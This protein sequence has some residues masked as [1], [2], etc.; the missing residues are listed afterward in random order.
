M[1]NIQCEDERLNKTETSLNNKYVACAKSDCLI[2]TI[3]L[4][5][6]YFLLLVVNCIS[7]YFYNK[8]CRSG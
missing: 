7:C 6:I 1:K 2:Q 8:K 5:I 3:S 4:V